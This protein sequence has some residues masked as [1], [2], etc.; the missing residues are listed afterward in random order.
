MKRN[1]ALALIFLLL[2][3]ILYADNIQ[4]EVKNIKDITT[5]IKKIG[6]LENN[7]KEIISKYE[8]S[9]SYFAIK[10][11]ERFLKKLNKIQ[12]DKN[13]LVIEKKVMLKTLKIHATKRL[14]ELYDIIF[15]KGNGKN[16]ERT[17]MLQREYIELKKLYDFYFQEKI[18]I[19][20]HKD[21]PKDILELKVKIMHAKINLLKNDIKN[22]RDIMDRL[23]KQIEFLKETDITINDEFMS[24]YLEFLDHS[25]KYL[26]EDTNKKM[27]IIDFYQGELNKLGGIDHEKN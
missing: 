9:K 23:N 27:S 16:F 4:A 15:N 17:L 14:K 11:R 2:M 25:K 22:N 5:K 1:F 26:I 8:H 3:P 20:I 19:I 12:S 13:K 24:D 21:E 6:K 7:Y 18:D 10:K